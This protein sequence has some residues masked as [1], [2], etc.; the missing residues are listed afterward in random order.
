MYRTLQVITKEIR[1]DWRYPY[2]GATPCLQAMSQITGMDSKYNGETGYQIV[3]EFLDNSE[4]WTG[5][6]SNSIKKE[7]NY[8][9]KK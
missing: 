3:S 5:D 9:L 1:K 4:S 2:I 7:L 6:V 8:M